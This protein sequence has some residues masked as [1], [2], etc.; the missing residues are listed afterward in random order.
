MHNWLI[1]NF[2]H[3]TNYYA[4]VTSIIFIEKIFTL[5]SKGSIRDQ[6]PRDDDDRPSPPPDDG[7]DDDVFPPAL[8]QGV[9]GP[10]GLRKRRREDDQVSFFRDSKVILHIHF[11]ILQMI[12]NVINDWHRPVYLLSCSFN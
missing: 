4:F 5:R 7:D 6:P 12:D 8:P 11:Y 2:Y 1:F 10:S 9:P 3:I